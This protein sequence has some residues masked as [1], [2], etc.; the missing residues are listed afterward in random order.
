MRACCVYRP[1]PA[2][3]ERRA[4]VAREQRAR[5]PPISCQVMLQLM[6][7]MPSSSALTQLGPR[8]VGTLLDPRI[9]LRLDRE[10]VTRFA[11]ERVRLRELRQ[12][13]M[14]VRLPEI[15]DV[16]DDAFVAIVDRARAARVGDAMRERIAI[17][18]RRIAELAVLEIEEASSGRRARDPP[19]RD[20]AP[21]RARRTAAGNANRVRELVARRHLASRRTSRRRGASCAP[22]DTPLPR[23]TCA[24][25][26]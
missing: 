1:Q 25:G 8:P 11:R 15:L 24:A 17:P 14:P 22:S 2:L 10:R 5:P 20:G 16:A 26:A 6:S 21:A 4:L 12:M 13:Q 7:R 3:A 9:D 19:R 18:L 23:R